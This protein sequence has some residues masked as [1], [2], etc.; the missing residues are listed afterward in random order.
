LG[1]LEVVPFAD[2]HLGDAARLLAGRHTRHRSAEPLL[3]QRYEAPAAAAVELQAAWSATDASGA[4]AT[5]DGRL[6]GYV[7][8]A[9]REPGVWGPNIWVEAAGHAVEAGEDVRDLYGLAAERWVEEGAQRHYALV[10]ATDAELV[11]AW[12][13]LGF[14][15]QQAHGVQEPRPARAGK[16]FEIREPTVDDV[17]ALIEVDLALPVHQRSSPVFSEQPLPTTELLC[18]EWRK[19]LEGDEERVLIGCLQGRPVA[20]WSVCD[21]SLSV[22]NRGLTL[23][24]RACYL[25]FAATLPEARGSGIGVELTEASLDAAHRDGY[26]A[27]VTDW[28]VTNLLASRFWPKRGFRDAF[29]RLY[30]SIP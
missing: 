18:E 14:G 27:M 16:T 12:F 25:A 1:R 23:P 24:E 22:H 3:P 26:A 8:G 13:R 6:V 4:A 15:H 29:F 20:C 2:G 30:R 10:P 21:A 17:Q 19:T 5:R 9:P 28:R 11:D 7:V